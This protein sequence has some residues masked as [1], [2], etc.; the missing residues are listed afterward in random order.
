MLER[1]CNAG[2]EPLPKGQALAKGGR[3]HG[4]ASRLGRRRNQSRRCRLPYSHGHPA[5]PRS[6]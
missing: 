1:L 3:E 2:H 6:A 5:S 4:H